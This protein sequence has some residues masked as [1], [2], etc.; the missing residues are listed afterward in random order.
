MPRPAFSERVNRVIPVICIKVPLGQRLSQLIVVT[1]RTH[2]VDNALIST[3]LI[4]QRPI[5]VRVDRNRLQNRR[6]QGVQVGRVFSVF[7][8]VNTDRQVG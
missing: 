3:L 7:L 4:L 5:A 2:A 6:D 8:S 1:I